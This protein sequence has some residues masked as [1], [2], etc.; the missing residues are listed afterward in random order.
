MSEVEIQAAYVIGPHIDKVS[1]LAITTSV[2]GVDLSLTTE[3]G[4]DV[5]GGRWLTLCAD[6]ADCYYFLNSS[7][8]GTPD[9]TA[10][11]GSGRCFVIHN[12][13]KESFIP[14]AGF[15]FLR[16]ITATGSGYVRAYLS[17]KPPTELRG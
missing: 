10:T 7:A 5:D 6:G 14:R 2:A 11:S 4:P 3:L 8:A 15:H 16:A 9:P 17:S 12:G 13:S 1:V